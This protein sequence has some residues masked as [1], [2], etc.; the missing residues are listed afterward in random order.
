MPQNHLQCIMEMVMQYEWH[1][2]GSGGDAHSLLNCWVAQL[3]PPQQLPR[4]LQMEM[5]WAVPQHL[6][7]VGVLEGE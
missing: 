3:L 5:V 6:P 2:G 4:L 1:S 7:L